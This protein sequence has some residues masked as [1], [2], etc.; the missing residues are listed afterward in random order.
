MPHKSSTA[1]GN[2]QSLHKINTAAVRRMWNIK[3]LETHP[4][5]LWTRP[6]CRIT[7]RPQPHCISAH[8]PHPPNSRPIR[9]HPH[10]RTQAT[11][12]PSQG[13]QN[14]HPIPGDWHSSVAFPSTLI[15]WTPTVQDDEKMLS[16]AEEEDWTLILRCL[17]VPTGEILL[18]NYKSVFT[19][20]HST[21]PKNQFIGQKTTKQYSC[22]KPRLSK[23]TWNIQLVAL[24][25]V[26]SKTNDSESAH[27]LL[28][29]LLYLSQQFGN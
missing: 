17:P 4:P 5:N 9:P 6:L 27:A 24:K 15:K 29:W 25:A 16:K 18:K 28:H 2:E 1:K 8:R 14:T 19:W 3:D 23:N 12:T 21:W 7:Q 22:H 11:P 13:T 10:V 26:L 20:R